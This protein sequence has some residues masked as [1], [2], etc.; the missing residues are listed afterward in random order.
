MEDADGAG[1]GGEAAGD[2]EVAAGVG[3]GEDFGAAGQDVTGFPGEEGFGFLRAGDAVDAGAAA[4]PGAF[5]EIDE[6]DAG[7]QAQ[8][9]A[10]RGG[11][12]LAVGEVAGI[13]VGERDGVRERRRGGRSAADGG[14][15]F[16]R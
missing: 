9:V 7:Q 1:G 15:P 8:Q 13:V 12:P 16:K 4:A 11:D 10:R 14:Q 6:A 5:R 2:L 3:G